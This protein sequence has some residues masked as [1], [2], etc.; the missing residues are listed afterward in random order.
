MNWTPEKLRQAVK[1]LGW[2]PFT[3]E[4]I[5]YKIVPKSIR[6]QERGSTLTSR[7]SYQRVYNFL[8]RMEKQGYIKIVEPKYGRDPVVWKWVSEKERRESRV[9]ELVERI[10][11][12]EQ[13]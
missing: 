6:R 1:E 11:G 3:V 8:K 9:Q 5:Y 13:E 12:Y 4:D 2:R 10:V 7:P